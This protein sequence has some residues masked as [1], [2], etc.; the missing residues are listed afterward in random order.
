MQPMI[1]IKR[2]AI[3]NEYFEE[4][5]EK[6]TIN[7]KIHKSPENDNSSSND[8]SFTFDCSESSIEEK[9]FWDQEYDDLELL[10]ELISKKQRKTKK[11][12]NKKPKENWL[13]I[14]EDMLSCALIHVDFIQNKILEA[15]Q[16][17]L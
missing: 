17:Q 4:K 11:Q 5:S 7:K 13:K 16:I 6:Y 9:R 1:S 14:H 8:D 2:K 15:F 3:L 10:E 12:N